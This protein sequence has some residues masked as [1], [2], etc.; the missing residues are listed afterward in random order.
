MWINAQCVDG[1]REY[2]AK[3]A[4]DSWKAITSDGGFQHTVVNLRSGQT[5]E[6]LA[7]ADS[8][9]DAMQSAGGVQL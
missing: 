6:L 2:I 4:V 8:F 7:H 5:I 3:A 1:S 9:A